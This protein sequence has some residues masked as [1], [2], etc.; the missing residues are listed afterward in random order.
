M[1]G[2]TESG[3]ERIAERSVEIGVEQILPK[4]LETRRYPNRFVARIWSSSMSITHQ[5]EERLGDFS[6]Y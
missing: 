3:L 4:P 5:I 1:R 6:S 2:M